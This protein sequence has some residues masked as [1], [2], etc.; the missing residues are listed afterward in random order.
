[1]WQKL[2]QPPYNTGGG[3]SMD[4]TSSVG[5]YQ[6]GDTHEYFIGDQN[7]N[8]VLEWV[9][10]YFHRPD[11]VNGIDDDGDGCVDELSYGDSTGQIG[12]DLVPDAMVYFETGILPR[13]AGKNADVVVLLDLQGGEWL[14]KTHKIGAMPRWHSYML[15]GI[16]Y[17]PQAFGDFISYYS[18]EYLFGVNSNPEMDNDMRDQFVGNIDIRGF[19]VRSP[20]NHLCSAGRQL[21]MGAAFQRY[22]GWVVTSYELVEQYDDHDWNGDGDKDDY[23]AAY[24]AVDPN[25][26]GCRQGVNGG[27]YGRNLKN[28]G[29]VLTAGYTWE[30]SDM[31]D[32]DGDGDEYDVVLLWH[33]INSSWPLKGRIYASFTYTA[34]IP[35]FGFGFWGIHTSYGQ[36]PTFPLR[37]G[38]SYSRYIGSIGYRTYFWVASDEDGDPQTELPSYEISSGRTVGNVGGRCTVIYAKEY[39]LG[40]DVNGDVDYHDLV[41]GIFCPDRHSGGG[42]WIVDP[43]GYSS[44]WLDLGYMYYSPSEFVV[45][46]SL[47]QV[48]LP[49][50]A[51]EP[52]ASCGPGVD[53]N[54]NNILEYVY[55]HLSYLFEMPP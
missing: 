25:S 53:L 44:P 15:R 55:I 43:D 52:H 5:E 18:W 1:L 17:F 10:Y 16:F 8:G 21:Y 48:A 24:Y 3:Y 9:S 33:D 42:S 45:E 14:L 29:Y 2:S 6:V 30:S 39:E 47:G 31:R 41:T 28:S 22:D 46:D 50:F 37:F 54:G 40:T 51:Y 13:L 35:E 12:C 32:W 34:P 19:P 20:V 4:S 7:G 26:G 36:F 23:V 38:G 27:V 11:S 49:F